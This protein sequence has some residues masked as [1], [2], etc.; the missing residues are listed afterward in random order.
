M[1]SY[2]S[3][4]TSA[5]SNVFFC[6][7]GAVAG[8][9]AGCVAGPVVGWT[10]GCAAGDIVVPEDAAVPVP[11]SGLSSGRCSPSSSSSRYP[12]RTSGGGGGMN[13]Q[14]TVFGFASVSNLLLPAASAVV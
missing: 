8:W 11:F 4:A 7:V 14:S 12:G 5:S 6:V 13:C 9:V 10:A 3:R 1:I 2:A